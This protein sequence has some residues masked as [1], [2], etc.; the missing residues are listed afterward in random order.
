MAARFVS[1]P[2]DP[3]GGFDAARMS[4][5][6]PGLPEK[7]RWRGR[8][9]SVGAVLEQWKDYGDCRHGSGERY[10]RRHFFRVRAAAG[11]VLTVY[12]QRS[13]GRASARVKSRW[14][15]YSVEKPD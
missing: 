2:I 14:W 7:F 3:A 9:F 1:E 5:G 8:E 10:V 11:E 13:F 15:L 12:F 6:E 4:F